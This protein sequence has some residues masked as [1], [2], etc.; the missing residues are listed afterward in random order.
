MNDVF[1]DTGFVVALSSQRDQHHRRARERAQ[2]VSDE[3]TQIVTTR[4]V[5]VEI[6][7][8]LSA[9]GRRNF[10]VRY[11]RSIERDTSFE[12]V[13]ASADLF[14]RGLALYDERPDKAWGLTD[15]ISFVVMR[16]RDIW[17]ALTADRD[18]EQAGFNALLRT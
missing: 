7:N 8:A 3:R 10:A 1:L 17:D 12:V 2:Q 11:I 4:D 18:F 16:D 6:G 14:H 15:C 13:E 5:L 9:V